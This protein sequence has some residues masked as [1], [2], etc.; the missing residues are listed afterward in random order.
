MSIHAANLLP[1]RSGGGDLGT[2]MREEEENGNFKA[3]EW[4]LLT[5]R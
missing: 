1:S 5:Y 3:I 2:E 4:H